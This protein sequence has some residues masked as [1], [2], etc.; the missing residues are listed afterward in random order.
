MRLSDVVADTL[1]PGT[2][3]DEISKVRDQCRLAAGLPE[4]GYVKDLTQ[5]Q[6]EAVARVVTSANKEI[7]QRQKR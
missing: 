3:P 2:S 1:P 4:G 5:P 6:I 7:R